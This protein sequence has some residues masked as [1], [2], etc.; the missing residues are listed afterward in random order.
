MRL[1]SFAVGVF[2]V[3]TFLVGLH[4]PD[5]MVFLL[6][7]AALACAITT[8]LSQRLSAFLKI[9][10]AT[11]AVET[12]IFGLAFLVDELGRWP[13]AYENY[14]LP[15]SLPFAVALFGVFI[16]AIS[17][18]PVVRKMIGIADPYFE[19]ATP[20]SAKIWPFPAFVVGQNKLAAAS[21]VFLIVVNQAEVALDV[22]LSYFR[23]DFTN[24]LKNLDQ[25]EFWRQLFLVFLPVV[26]VLVAAYTIEYVVTSTFVIRWRR[27]LTAHYTGRW[28]SQGTHYKMLL[29]GSPTDNPD[30]RISQDIYAFIDGGGAGSGIYGYS[31]TALQNLT[32][33]VSYAI[34]LWT[35]STGFT[36]PGLAIVIPGVL[37][38]VALAYTGAGTLITHWVGHSLTNLYFTQQRFEANFR[39][40]LARAREY[41]EQIALLHGEENEARAANGKFH[42]I[43]D[44]YMRI[45]AVRKRLTALTRFY[46]QASVFIPYVVAAPF[47]FAGKLTLGALNQV[48]AAFN[49]VNES[50][51]F[52]VT[53]YVGLT[54]FKAT[55][56]RLTSFD[57]AIARAQALGTRDPRI[58]F[59]RSATSDRKIDA[60]SLALPD[61]RALVHVENITLAAHEPTLL[62]GRSG[63]GK[64]TLFRAIAGIW[65]FGQGKIAEP[66]ASLMLLPQRPYIPIG[67]LRAAIAYPAPVDKF[68]E[69]AMREALE[70]AGLAPLANQLDETDNW[71]MRL[72]G[73]EQQRLAIARALLAAPDWLFLDEATSAL[74]E[75]SEAQIYR[76]IAQKLP[77][78]TLVS[79]GHSAT[80]SAFHKRRIEMQP[81]TDG[82]ATVQAA[83]AEG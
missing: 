58:D 37:F 62:V 26:V 74:D 43:F 65:P 52:F 34:V 78:T 16:Y 63:S 35:L 60:L 82:P 10:E 24:A 79:I 46:L 70:A 29:A 72:S 51:N 57:D 77:G 31:I 76:A 15:D 22:R 38:W 54:D 50:M 81:Q 30:Q 75:A 32:S 45:V 61:G 19:A 44:N 14:T 28:M 59:P 40:G 17:F 3:A 33:L 66:D 48:G 9:F 41:S 67:S 4:T 5:T 21:L 53:Y 6:A 12:I 25:A 1:L 23:A 8:F 18:I 64:S 83:T 20:T 39:F 47:Y 68:A 7:G 2:A 13:K 11:F 73:G 27:W 36:L 71:Q 49:S 69:A 55:L 42:D 80:L 56:N